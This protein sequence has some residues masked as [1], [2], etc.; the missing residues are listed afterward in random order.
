MAINGV[1]AF[2]D[3]YDYEYLLLDGME[4]YKMDMFLRRM[5][6]RIY[7]FFFFT[8]PFCTLT[9]QVLDNF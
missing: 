4:A 1:L 9:C 5:G 7:P 8:V 6:R 2:T 3:T